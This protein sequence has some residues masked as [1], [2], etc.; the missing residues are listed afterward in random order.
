MR[1]SGRFEE[2]SMRQMRQFHEMIGREQMHHDLF[3]LFLEDPWRILDAVWFHSD[4]ACD[5]P[6]LDGA[7]I[8]CNLK[9]GDHLRDEDIPWKPEIASG[10]EQLRV[11]NVPGRWTVPEI[12]RR[13]EGMF[14]LLGTLSD[15]FRL[16]RWH[17]VFSWEIPVVALGSPIPKEDMGRTR[18]Y[19]PVM[20]ERTLL[21][22]E[23]ADFQK[24]A[25][26]F[27]LGRLKRE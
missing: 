16:A 17:E 5:M 20:R 11:Q 7:L 27:Y 10:F 4:K 26:I 18:T 14:L 24:A 6:S 15:L 9:L 1:G 21:V 2:P 19:Y 12:K 25:K 22:A 23:E 13:L 8:S 3:Q